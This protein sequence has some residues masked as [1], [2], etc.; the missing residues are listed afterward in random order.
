[1]IA[2]SERQSATVG[3]EAY[4][5]EMS[6]VNIQSFFEVLLRNN[7][8]R[9]VNDLTTLPIILQRFSDRVWQLSA[10]V[11]IAEQHVGLAREMST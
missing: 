6:I 5:V 1:M 4:L 3:R 11:Y 10:W 2:V 7:A 9:I 8:V